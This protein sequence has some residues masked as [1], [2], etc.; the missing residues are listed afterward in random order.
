MY[1]RLLA[2][3]KTKNALHVPPRSASAATLVAIYRDAEKKHLFVA[4]KHDRMLF[5]NFINRLF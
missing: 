1:N 3:I 5:L 2:Y 4:P